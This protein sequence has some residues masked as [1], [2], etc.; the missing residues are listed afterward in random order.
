MKWLAAV[1]AGLL[2]PVLLAIP[3]QAHGTLTAT[4]PSVFKVT[5]WNEKSFPRMS[6]A[7]YVHDLSWAESG[8]VKAPALVTLGAEFNRPT[9][10]IAL[11]RR[12]A[13]YNNLRVRGAGFDT[14]EVFKKR[15][16]FHLHGTAAHVFH[17]GLGH[18]SPKRRYVRSWGKVDGYPVTF[19]ALHLTNGCFP[20][21]PWRVQRCRALHEEI[22]YV[23]HMV[24]RIHARNR[25]AIIGGDMNTEHEIV[26]GKRQASIRP[27]TLMQIAVVPATG[28]R[29]GIDRVRWI[30]RESWAGLWTD[31]L[32]PNVRVHLT[33][34]SWGLR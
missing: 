14:I 33:K 34:T 6:H 21:N 20:L 22:V 15:R 32:T 18:H 8:W 1:L 11:T 23:R 7:H 27:R 3:A 25:T 30:A 19:V 29:A 12:R 26:W 28:V 9:G 5:A 17:R 31:H 13:A 10:E 16:G 4:G 24:R 2:L